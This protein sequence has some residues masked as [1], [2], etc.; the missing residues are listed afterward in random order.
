MIG[1]HAFIKSVSTGALLDVLGV[2]PLLE[3]LP[4]HVLLDVLA[5]LP[6]DGAALPPGDVGAVLLVLIPGDGGGDAA[7]DLVR[8][9]VTDFTRSVDIIADLEEMG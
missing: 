1:S 9:V 2:A 5:L 4:R 7:A 3:G 6:G 8:D